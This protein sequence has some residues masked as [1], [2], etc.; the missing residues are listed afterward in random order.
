LGTAARFI[1]R[2]GDAQVSVYADF[3]ESLGYYGE[4]Y[5]EIY[6]YSGDTWRGPLADGEGLIDAISTAIGQQEA[7]AIR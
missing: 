1:V 7:K 5:W 4:P 3:D 2:K 6:P